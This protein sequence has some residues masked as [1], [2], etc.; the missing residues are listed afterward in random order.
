LYL[1]RGHNRGTH[2]Q[3]K[4]NQ[5]LFIIINMYTYSISNMYMYASSKHICSTFWRSF[6]N[7]MCYLRYK[8]FLFIAI[9][10]YQNTSH[11]H[12]TAYYFSAIRI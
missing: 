4:I 12:H 9:T 7:V 8:P 11:I 3:F 1:S 10:S 6:H 2:V 5:H